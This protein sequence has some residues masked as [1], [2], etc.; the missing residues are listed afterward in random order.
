MKDN[1][2]G[3][4]DVCGSEYEITGYT[5]EIGCTEEEYGECHTCGMFSYEYSYGAFAYHLKPFEG[6]AGLPQL[7]YSHNNP[8]TMWES[9]GYELMVIVTK[10][11]WKHEKSN[12]NS[13]RA[14]SD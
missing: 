5:G 4:C 6:K 14:N 8:P 3:I 2:I 12:R 1:R 10:G 7:A 11:I 13:N 9:F